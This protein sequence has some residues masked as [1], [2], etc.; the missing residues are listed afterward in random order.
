[1]ELKEISSDLENVEY[2]SRDTKG[3]TNK[4]KS[5]ETIKTIQEENMM[6]SY[7]SEDRNS[8]NVDSDK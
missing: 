7:I 1:M 2:E 3:K 4:V 5:I 8:E 6:D